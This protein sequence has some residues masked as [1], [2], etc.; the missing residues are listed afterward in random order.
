[1]TDKS[2]KSF[3]D[4]DSTSTSLISQVR[5][6]DESA[7]IRLV[8]VYSP[9]VYRWCLRCGLQPTDIDDICQEVFRSV[10]RGIAG[11]RKDRP[12]DSFRAWLRTITMNRIRDEIAKR[13]AIG[14]G[15]STATAR[16]AEIADPNAGS[17]NDDEMELGILF[18]RL[19]GV[20]R[21]EFEENSWQSFWRTVVNEQSIASVA[22]DLHMT[23][24]AIYLAKSRILRRLRTILEELGETIPPW[25]KNE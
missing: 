18:R 14:A 15:G 23:P 9:L 22:A 20:I 13:P 21:T 5:R 6:N 1:M 19:M 3:R 17:A 2:V 12:G 24:N 16:I 4:D 25:V 7:W 10:H 8:R 11:F